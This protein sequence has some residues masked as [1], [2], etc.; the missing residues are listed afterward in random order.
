MKVAGEV[1]IFF[2]KKCK[3][4]IGIGVTLIRGGYSKKCTEPMILDAIEKNLIKFQS[5]ILNIA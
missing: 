4:K 2:G 3:K 1:K 5:Y